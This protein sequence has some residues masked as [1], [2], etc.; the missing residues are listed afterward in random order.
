MVTMQVMLVSSSAA[1]FDTMRD[2]PPFT[3]SAW[4]TQVTALLLLLPACYQLTRLDA[5]ELAADWDHLVL[6]EYMTA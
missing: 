4:R 1:V 2:V 6:H 3:L 5:G